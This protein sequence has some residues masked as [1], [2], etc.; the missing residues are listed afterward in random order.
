[1]LYAGLLM[2][3]ERF[4]FVLY[5][6]SEKQAQGDFGSQKIGQATCS[7]LPALLSLPNA[8]CWKEYTKKLTFIWLLIPGTFG[9]SQQCRK[10]AANQSKTLQPV[11]LQ[12]ALSTVLYCYTGFLFM[13]RVYNQTF[14]VVNPVPV[15]SS[16]YYIYINPW[17]SLQGTISWSPSIIWAEVW[18]TQRG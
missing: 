4:C 1:M 10:A 5:V 16:L 7:E 12:Q 17:A 3:L 11:C 18:L 8:E 13:I 9:A 6:L 2:N 14:L 15:P